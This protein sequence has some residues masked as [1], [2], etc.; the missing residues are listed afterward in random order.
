[1]SAT[2]GPLL[3]QLGREAHAAIAEREAQA[4]AEAAH[5]RDTAAAQRERRR[6]TTL[7]EHERTLARQR[8]DARARVAQSTV[9]DVLTAR[10]AF[11]TRLFDEAARRLDSLASA[12]DL[13]ARL[14]PLFVEA[15]PFLAEDDARAR[16]RPA[17]RT[18]VHDALAAAGRA[19]MPI[20]DDDAVPTGAMFENGTGTVRVDA[21]LVAR[22]RR[23]RA[24]LAIVAVHAIEDATP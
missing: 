10:A 20:E 16:C 23:M 11:L 8:E 5:I 14:T 9:H 4:R 21:T 17:V 3:E 19:D 2:A 1:M 12:P 13:A 15:L 7:A 18:A 24:T 22:L 6:A